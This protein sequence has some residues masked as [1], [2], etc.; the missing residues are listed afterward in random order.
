M[1]SQPE[2]VIGSEL[3]GTVGSVPVVYPIVK[4]TKQYVYV[5]VS[6]WASRR[7][8]ERLMRFLVT[9]LEAEGRAW[10]MANQAGVYTGP[11]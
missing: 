2:H 3:Y 11:A 1:T 7:P 8:G 10:N 9:E 4:R 6:P 5:P